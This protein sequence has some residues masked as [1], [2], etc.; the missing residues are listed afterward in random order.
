MSYHPEEFIGQNI[1]ITKS[2]NKTQEEI[3]GKIIDETKNTITII[4][5]ENK[6][7]KLLKKDIE[8]TIN[9]KTINGKKIQKKPEERIKRK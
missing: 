9:E 6:T 4:T 3:K 1:K 7:K 8:F 2:K 5:E